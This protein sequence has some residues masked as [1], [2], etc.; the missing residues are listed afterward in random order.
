MARGY[1]YFVPFLILPG[2]LLGLALWRWKD[3][4]ARFLLLTC[5]LP[6]RWFYDSFTLWLIP[7]TRRSILATVAC[8]WF[9]GIWRW[10][11]IPHSM[12]QVG[13]WCVFS[14]YLPMLM[15]V[16]SRELQS[17]S[18]T[19]LAAKSAQIRESETIISSQDPDENS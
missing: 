12:Q 13:R 2:P 9:A 18:S 17:G 4:D 1:R 3:R 6:Q 19:R 11:Q 10:Y 14:F 5:L 8:S 16:L 15:V 7:K